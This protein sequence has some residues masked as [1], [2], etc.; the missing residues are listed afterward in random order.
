MAIDIE[1]IQEDVSTYSDYE[2]EGSVSRAKLYR[3]ALRR[4]ITF[5]TTSSS[6]QGSSLSQ[7]VRSLE[8]LMARVNDFIAANDTDSASTSRVRFL[9]VENG[10]R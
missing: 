10:F 1:Q 2:D 9:S 3:T 4:L 7:D 6:N 8:N 5:R